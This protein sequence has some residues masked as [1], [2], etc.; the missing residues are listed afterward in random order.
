MIGLI[1]AFLTTA[2]FVPQVVKVIKT[3]DTK[4]LSL[5]MYIMQVTGM[6]LWLVHGLSINDLPLIL[7][8]A[9]TLCLSGIILFY[10][11]RYK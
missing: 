5:L 8:N 1:A 11:I 3:K 9:V 2:A 6:F 7:A 10:K 4:G